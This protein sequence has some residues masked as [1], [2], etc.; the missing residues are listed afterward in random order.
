MSA[1]AF[2]AA[3]NDI[4]DRYIEEAVHYRAPVRRVI[5][6]ILRG[7]AA[8]CLAL[9][10]GFSA[11]LVV[12]VEAREI[13]FGWIR[14]QVDEF[15]YYSYEEPPANLETEPSEEPE[16]VIYEM[17]LIPEGYTLINHFS[18]PGF[19]NIAYVN[20]E[21]HLLTFHYAEPEGMLAIKEAAY[22]A[23]YASTVHGC[24][25]DIYIANDPSEEGNTIVWVED[26]ILFNISGYFDMETLI[27][28]AESVAVP[29]KEYALG[30]IPEGFTLMLHDPYPDETLYAYANYDTGNLLSFSY[31]RGSDNWLTV[32]DPKNG[33]RHTV[34]VRGTEADLYLPD[35]PDTE[36]ACLVWFED[37]C[38]MI[39]QGHFTQEEIIQLAESVTEVPY[40]PGT[41]GE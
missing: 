5:R 17:T 1:D 9:I 4:H 30:Y 10:I 16:D 19:T 13:V 41:P 24:E 15:S 34:T 35:D 26:D 6:P 36:S 2:F 28:L 39:I 8:A 31:T 33:T 32:V 40:S 23:M 7:L 18:S 29:P 3:L 21:G 12:S 22:A 38:M 37:D 14:E 27:E 20:A 11:I 25:A